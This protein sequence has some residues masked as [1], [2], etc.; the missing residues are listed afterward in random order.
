[1][2]NLALLVDDDALVLRSFQRSLN[3][4]YDVE[5]AQNPYEAIS[6][7]SQGCDVRVI[8]T[9]IDMPGMNGVNFLRRLNSEWPHIYCIVLTGNQ[10]PGL[11]S[12]LLRLP[13]VV[14]VFHK[15]TLSNA[16]SPVIRQ[17]MDHKETSAL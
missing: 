12:Q 1:M 4:T 9:D 14:R 10:D 8:V 11:E 16:I 5:T 6:K 2:R 13:N 7:L 15:P 17:F 3:D